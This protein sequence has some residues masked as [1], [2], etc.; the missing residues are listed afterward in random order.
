MLQV[1]TLVV[2]AMHFVRC[3]IK[4]G[5]VFICRYQVLA[6]AADSKTKE[7]SQNIKQG[8]KVAVCMRY[9]LHQIQINSTKTTL[10]QINREVPQGSI[11]TPYLFNTCSS[12][13]SRTAQITSHKIVYWYANDSRLSKKIQSNKDYKTLQS[14]LSILE[15]FIKLTN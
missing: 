13:L 6:V 10:N 3:H 4:Q 9:E 5:S 8:K 1:S 11:F 14:N 7:E 15:T 2:I 12:T